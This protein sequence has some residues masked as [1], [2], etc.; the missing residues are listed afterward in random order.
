MTETHDHNEECACA[1]PKP[2]SRFGILKLSS[3]LKTSGDQNKK[4]LISDIEYLNQDQYE[5]LEKHTQ[6]K[7][8]TFLQGYWAKKVI[9]AGLTTKTSKGEVLAINPASI[10]VIDKRWKG[11]S[12]CICGKAI[13]YEYW[14]QKYGPIGSVHILEHTGLDKELVRDITKGYKYQNSLR[15]ELVELL[16]ALKDNNETVADWYVKFKLEEKTE[17]IKRLA[18][19]YK[20]LAEKLIELKLPF[21]KNLR[22]RINAIHARGKYSNYL[23]KASIVVIASTAMAP[24]IPLT[25]IHQALIDRST[26]TL[27]ASRINPEIMKSNG[28]RIHT[29]TDLCRALMNG[30]P[31]DSQVRYATQ[32]CEQ[33]EHEKPQVEKKLEVDIQVIARAALTRALV[34]NPGDVFAKNLY[35][36]SMGKPLTI[37]Q[38]TVIFVQCG[39]RPSL[40]DRYSLGSHGI[41]RM[42]LQDLLQG[43]NPV[44]QVGP[45]AFAP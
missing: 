29:L 24:Q 18:P 6:E 22:D 10:R 45:T 33:L 27:A 12:H 30:H 39:N 2:V 5:F 35:N 4:R 37:K 9:D 42:T 17:C 41:A 20:V 8:Y 25:N 44:P 43:S 19:E 3:V 40:Y 14:I 38:L 16:V 13:R 21:D 11:A 32:L 23:A 1:Q 26:K 36:Y 15:T 34:S 7:F 28:Y 31:S